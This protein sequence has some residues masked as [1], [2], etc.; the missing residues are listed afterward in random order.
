MKKI[1]CL[2]DGLGLGGA[3]RQLVGLAHLLQQK[4]Y[5]VDLVSYHTNDFY[6][7]LVNS[8]GI[9][10]IQLKPSGRKLSKFRLVRSLVKNN[11]YDV[12]ISYLNGP[13]SIACLCKLTGYKGKVIVSDR[14]VKQNRGKS[15][16]IL[17]AMYRFANH[18]VPNSHAQA[19]YIA[20]NFP[21][22]SRKVTAITNFT[23][24]EKFKPLQFAGTSSGSIQIMCAG[25]ISKE[26]NII[27]FMRAIKQTIEK[28]GRDI[29]VKWFGNIGLNQEQYYEQ[30]CAERSQMGLDDIFEV[31]PATQDIVEEYRKCDV[32]C[33][34][35][36]YEGFPNVIC[37]AMACGK[38]I[39]CSNV[40][41]NPR[42]V[43]DGVNGFLFNPS[44][45]DS[46]VDAVM[47]FLT[48]S[49]KE[50]I[51]M[52]TESRNIAENKFSED[53]FVNKYIALI[54]DER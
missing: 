10:H 46:V 21:N 38:P 2:I 43:S 17:Y 48:L 12:V 14:I 35:S 44:D 27:G 34:P 45:M 41:D 25:R 31:H 53:V 5:S 18:I 7:P 52:G 16:Q 28:R 19:E 29:R 24:I 47:R 51:A 36:F 6:L 50:R 32:F 3:Q 22:L 40:C 20:Q 1:L 30:I 42:I 39:L 13:N 8:L 9:N 23:D 4:G 15:E 33:L 54:E 49:D 26:K 37:E 11:K